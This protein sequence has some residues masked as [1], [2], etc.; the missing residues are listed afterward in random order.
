MESPKVKY[1][2]NE[3]RKNN[4]HFIDI[5]FLHHNFSLSSEQFLGEIKW[6]RV[7]QIIENAVYAKEQNALDV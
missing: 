1:L 5:E 3:F 4:T 6:L 2:I 7:T